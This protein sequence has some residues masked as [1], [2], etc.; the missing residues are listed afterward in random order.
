MFSV[1]DDG[2]GLPPGFDPAAS[3]GLGMRLVLSL[4]RQLGGTLEASNAGGGARF[5]VRVPGGGGPS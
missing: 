2:P 1:A 3:G 5:V 4:A